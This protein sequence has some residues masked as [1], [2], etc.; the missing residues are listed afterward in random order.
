MHTSFL[1]LATFRRLYEC[2][3][4]Q[5]HALHVSC[6]P[7]LKFWIWSEKGVTTSKGFFCLAFLTEATPR[8]ADIEQNSSAAIPGLRAEA[9]LREN[10]G[11]EN[12]EKAFD[13]AVALH[14]KRIPHT[15]ICISAQRRTLRN[16]EVQIC[17]L[18]HLSV[19][20]QVGK[21]GPNLFLKGFLKASQT[22]FEIF[23]NIFKNSTVVR[24]FRHF[25]LL[26]R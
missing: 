21:S 16:P 1:G 10:W 9:L 17:S 18:G 15:S 14:L 19:F 23:P 6:M 7:G 2:V 25:W 13:D 24:P 11:S 20:K 4:L 5:I 3:Q 22:T 8:M 26:S 12:I